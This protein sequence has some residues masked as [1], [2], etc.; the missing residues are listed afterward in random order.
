MAVLDSGAAAS[1]ITDRLRKKLKLKIDGPSKT[2]IIIA[3]GD[4]QRALGE[5]KSVGIAIQNLLIPMR[6]QVIDSAD[7]TLLLGTDFFDKTEA[8]WDFRTSSINL[9]YNGHIDAAQIIWALIK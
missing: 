9:T 2:V 7:E 6:L 8:Q 5:I 3:N 4:R 1:I